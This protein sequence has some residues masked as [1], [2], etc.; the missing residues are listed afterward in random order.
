MPGKTAKRPT[1]WLEVAVANG[2][3]RKALKALVWAHV[4][5]ITRTALGHD[6]TAEEVAEWWHASRRT[7]FRE[8]AAFRECF[9]ML[10]SPA[11]LVDAPEV[12]QAHARLAKASGDL[13]ARL[14][15]KRR[16]PSD[17]SI[18]QLGMGP[19]AF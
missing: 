5:G 8:Q 6:P 11:P 19:A 12:H 4:W 9:P 1:T 2:G 3:F 18:L 17:A 13:D 16:I 15:A 14:Q 7:T 10:D